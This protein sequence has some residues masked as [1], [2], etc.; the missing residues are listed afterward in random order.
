MGFEKH[1][2]SF[3][4]P[5]VE[6]SREATGL[7][8]LPRFALL[9]ILTFFVHERWSA[10]ESDVL[11][12]QLKCPAQPDPLLPPVVWRFDE[13][14]QGKSTALLEQAVVSEPQRMQLTSS[15]YRLRATMIMASPTRIPAG[16]LSLTFSSG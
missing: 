4:Q 16:R 2:E 8:W 1:T 6:P 14:E 11:E 10:R 7:K 12:Y 13:E 5:S 3:T 15:G 9:A